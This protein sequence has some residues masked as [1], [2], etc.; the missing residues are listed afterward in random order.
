[1]SPVF[2]LGSALLLATGLSA[3]TPHTAI[4][5]RAE[6][7]T[8]YLDG[9]KL[10]GPFVIKTDGYWMLLDA[11]Q[12]SGRALQDLVLGDSIGFVPPDSGLH[13][14]RPNDVLVVMDRASV[15]DERAGIPEDECLVRAIRLVGKY[16]NAVESAY[17]KRGQ[18]VVR[19]RGHHDDY[20]FEMGSQARD[21]AQAAALGLPRLARAELLR[22]S[23]EELIKELTDGSPILE[24]VGY[25]MPCMGRSA[26]SIAAKA[27]SLRKGYEQA[28]PPEYDWAR[29]DVKSPRPLSRRMK[30]LNQAF[31]LPKTPGGYE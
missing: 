21:S 7:G 22:A 26:E 11:R 6:T 25:Q 4:L 30:N 16:T 12:P 3:H 24:G 10:I 2:S 31:A 19:F 29:E 1:M 18:G 15:R 17:T 20:V 27:D 14:A 13:T 9:N 8:L 23:A 28:W 5:G